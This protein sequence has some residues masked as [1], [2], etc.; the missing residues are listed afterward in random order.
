M[1]KENLFTYISAYA[2]DQFIYVLYSGERVKD[3]FDQQKI[4]MATNS[5]FTTGKEKK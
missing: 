4:P 3:C 5:S 1:S 2:T